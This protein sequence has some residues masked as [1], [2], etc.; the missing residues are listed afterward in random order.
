MEAS[1]EMIEL[2]IKDRLLQIAR[3]AACAE[4]LSFVE[5][6]VTFRIANR[7]KEIE[8]LFKEL[9]ALESK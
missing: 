4:R 8:R 6:S 2:M 7:L 1:K 3:E 9:D 5:K